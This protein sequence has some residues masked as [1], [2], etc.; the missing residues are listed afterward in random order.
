[1]MTSTVSAWN[2]SRH[3]DHVKRAVA[4]LG[5]A[6]ERG[7]NLRKETLLAQIDGQVEVAGLV[8]GEKTI[9]ADRRV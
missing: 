2:D 6:I 7:G 5:Q 9:P 1:V 4:T 3:R 8:M